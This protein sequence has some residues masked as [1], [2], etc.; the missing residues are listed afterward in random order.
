MVRVA[1]HCS[2]LRHRIQLNGNIPLPCS[3]EAFPRALATCIPA[4]V[5]WWRETLT[6]NVMEMWWSS[7]PV[8]SELWITFF[9]MWRDLFDRIDDRSG[10]NA[11]HSTCRFNGYVNLVTF[12]CLVVRRTTAGWASSMTNWLGSSLSLSFNARSSRPCLGIDS[13]RRL[14]LTTVFSGFGSDAGHGADV[15][16]MSVELSVICA[17]DDLAWWE[18]DLVRRKVFG[19]KSLTRWNRLRSIRHR[20][21]CSRLRRHQWESKIDRWSWA[22]E[23]KLHEKKTD[24]WSL[25]HGDSPVV[26]GMDV[27][28]AF[29]SA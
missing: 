8:S 26:E 9:S 28:D 10:K 15:D 18:S 21:D 7:D 24:Y 13:F 1:D 19:C 5:A 11:V 27:S 14:R 6:G 20:L 12:R 22:K 29:F 4:G 23:V 17:L 2:T 3:E 25:A 16:C